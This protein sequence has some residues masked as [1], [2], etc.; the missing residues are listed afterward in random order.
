MSD[1]VREVRA[2]LAEMGAEVLVMLNAVAAALHGRDV[3]A[4]AGV[5]AAAARVTARGAVVESAS[6]RL[7]VAPAREAEVR[8]CAAAA[9]KVAHE[10]SRI[11]AGAAAAVRAAERVSAWAPGRLAVVAEMGH[12]ATAA[13]ARALGP[14]REDAG[15]APAAD[16]AEA[17][18]REEA[19]LRA[20]VDTVVDDP[21][22]IAASLQVLRVVCELD[23]A[24][25]RTAAVAGRV[26]LLVRV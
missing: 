4:G 24:A 11:A 25:G 20:L 9:L 18:P 6:L 26:P 13:L 22:R 23:C 2:H 15:E 8:G 5:A 10:L 1:A 3:R 16:A 7:L 17:T 19:L 14:L 12:A 21:R